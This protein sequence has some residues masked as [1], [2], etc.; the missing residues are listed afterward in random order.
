[1]NENAKSND[2]EIEEARKKLRA[3]KEKLQEAE[4]AWENDG[5][6]EALKKRPRKER[7]KALNQKLEIG[8]KILEIENAQIALISGKVAE[9]AKALESAT[10]DVGDALQTLGNVTRILKAITALLSILTKIL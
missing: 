3:A 4:Q 5:F 6:L 10:K 9:N 2:Q 1:M 8:E 7:E